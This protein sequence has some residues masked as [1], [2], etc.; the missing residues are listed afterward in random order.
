MKTLVTF[1][2]TWRKCE[3]LE[4]DNEQLLSISEAE[5]KEVKHSFEL[6]E[7]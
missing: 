4:L 1:L 2:W 5:D 7:L 3:T 6:K